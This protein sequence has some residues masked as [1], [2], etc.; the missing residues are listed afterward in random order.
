MEATVITGA[1]NI[2]FARVLSLRG[3]LRLETKGL[4]RHGRS[5]Y[6]IIKEEFGYRGNKQ[7]VLD[8]INTFINEYKEK[9]YDIGKS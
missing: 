6:S 4:K 9:H 8:Q 7:R 1:A 5:A 2:A 3:M